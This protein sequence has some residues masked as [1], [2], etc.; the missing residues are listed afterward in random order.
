MTQR[1]LFL[2]K[3]IYVAVMA[4]LLT[5]MYWLARPGVSDVA[6][7]GGDSGGIL[8]QLRDR[9]QL[10]QA[11]L[12][13]IDP[14]GETIKLS[15]LG[16]RGIAANVLWAKAETY[17]MRKD[18]DS[19]SATLE[20]IAKVQPNF[21]S[22][23][24]YQSW[25]LSYNCA[26]EFDDYR[27]R[28]RWV[29]K[30]I[31]YLKEGI[32]H[33]SREPSL[34][35]NVGWFCSN[36]IGKAD[37]AKQYRRLFKQD[38]DF[39]GSLPV[40]DRD[41][42]LVGRKWF[43]EG[44]RLVDH[45]GA[46]FRGINP[47]IYRSSAPLSSLYYAVAK[48]NDGVFSEA[49]RQ[50][51]HA[52]AEDWQRYGTIDIPIVEKIVRLGEKEIIE[53][54]VKQLQAQLDAVQPGLREKLFAEKRNR[55][56]AKQRESLDTP[57]NR[58]SPQQIAMAAQCEALVS[59]SRAEVARQVPVAHRK[60]AEEL[61]GQIAE[62]ESLMVTIQKNRDIVG[63]DHWQLRAH[64]EQEEE[65]LRARGEIYA[66]D[67]YFADA[68]VVPARAAYDRGLAAWRKVLDKHP[69]LVNEPAT[70]GDLMEIVKR[71]QE[72]LSKREEKLPANFILKD[73]V[74]SDAKGA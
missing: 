12:G 3:V 14:A 7:Q 73:I 19:L 8:A 72:I 24:R 69:I 37:E 25:N 39:H 71:Y 1:R 55:L 65:S 57:R 74:E 66:G 30:G 45:D 5:P 22:V 33:N 17:K 47:L 56:S 59:V 52:G 15:V 62:A 38:N 2:R 32:Q 61:A 36:K 20:Q 18:W 35:W 70:R 63:W 27:E 60:R 46:V 53:E 16:M 6:G 4:G 29:I 58:R 31:N 54:R 49:A 11:S 48:E 50:A 23:W 41:N 21:V 68:R 28:Y 9:Y 10:G 67:Q 40:E 51:W 44:E 34:Q 43:L 13:E 42:W 26:A 64:W